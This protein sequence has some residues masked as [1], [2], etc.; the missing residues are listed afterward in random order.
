MK[1]KINKTK[2][3][4]LKMFLKLMFLKSMIL[5]MFLKLMKLVKMNKIRLNLNRLNFKVDY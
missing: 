1:F 5:K 2:S 4:I 3:M